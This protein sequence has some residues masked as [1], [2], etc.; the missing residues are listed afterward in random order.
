MLTNPRDAMLCRPAK[1][2][3]DQMMRGGVIV[4]LSIFKMAVRYR[5]FYI[6]LF[7]L[8]LPRCVVFGA[9]DGVP[10]GIRYRHKGSQNLIAGI[11]RWS[12]ALD[13]VV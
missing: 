7:G 12:K 2:G 3:K 6:G 1:F 11:T 5:D 9:Y 4:Y 10:L 13:I 8:K